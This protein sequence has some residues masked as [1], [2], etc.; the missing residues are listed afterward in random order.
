MSPEEL[1]VAQAAIEQESLDLGIARYKKEREDEETA[2]RPGK[3]LLMQALV[4]GAQAIQQWISDVTS[5]KPTAQANYGYF[6]QEFDPHLLAWVTV[7]L[8]INAMHR[9][10]SFQTVALRIAKT[11]EDT[12]NFDA[13]KAQDPRAYGILQR[14]IAQSSDA[15]YRHI[16]MRRQ[17][18]FAG[19]RAIKWE[20]KQKLTVG[21]LLLDLIEGAVFINGSPLFEKKYSGART[22]YFLSPTPA[23]AEWLERSHEHCQ[24][25]SPVHMPMVVK[26]NHWTTVDDGGYRNPKLR[27]PLVKRKGG[28]AYLEELRNYEMPMVYAAINALQNTAFRV[29]PAVLR[30]M[31]EV[32]D[33]DIRVNKMPTRSPLPLP[34]SA[35]EDASPAEITQVKAA[36]AAVHSHNA[37]T[38]SKRL[39][40][41][42]KL[43]IADKFVSYERIYFPHALDWRGRA[44][45]LASYLHPQADDT[46][47][48]LL[49]FADGV[50]LG[51]N[52]AFWLAVHGANCYGVD[53]VSFEERV[54]WVLDNEAAIL[55]SATRPIEGA[56]FWAKTD[57]A[58][59]RFL[60]F[61][62]EW[63]GYVMSGR[64]DAF[65]SHIPVAFDGSCNGLQNYSMMLR[66]EVG[67]A[68]T[69]LVPSEKPSDIYTLVAERLAVQV[70]EDAAAGVKGAAPWIGKINR[71]IAKQ[72]TMTMPYGAGQF[73]YRAQIMDAVAKLS[74]DLGKPYLGDVD[75]FQPASYLAVAIKK[76]LGGVVVKA[77]EA[78]EWLQEVSR[79]AAEDA[80][81][82]RWESPL[83]MPILQDYRVGVAEHADI[84]VAGRRYKLALVQ[85]GTK[86]DKRRQAMGIAP[87]FV[88]SLDAAHMMHTV[89]RCLENGVDAFCM[90]HDSFGAH[91][92]KADV[93]SNALR[94]V[95]IE[96]YSGDVLGEFHTL[97]QGQ[98]PPKLAKKLPPPP[99][100][101][102]LDPEAVR[103]SEYF[104]A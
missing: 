9:Q 41:G 102:S 28:A 4:P 3:R 23:T 38:L 60:A 72:P 6:L 85:M 94:D 34:P 71:K 42:A 67:G 46:G 57:E 76:A 95:F 90:V 8:A 56:M 92:G 5:G 104:F 48:A 58:P 86:L 84:V 88:H 11:L 29:N 47:K 78:M 97:L 52:G 65:K 82:L 26:P 25:L 99:A 54:Q 91:A 16:V 33:A 81:P 36:K 55:D 12:L 40:M 83:G 62:F 7:K 89:V 13:L 44:Y 24:I 98:L 59:W 77:A 49:E 73:G 74:E 30:V 101:G 32:W 14:K 27:V 64:S 17:Q 50:P 15:R 51:D 61:C 45:P 68:A 20:P 2:T 100:K 70:K 19:V 87:N 1:E 43:W 75:V 31:R 79:V 80:L 18:K 93:L 66:D 103:Q 21:V 10:D 63:A 53:K 22:P 69:N 96:Q 39:G 37:R 35:P